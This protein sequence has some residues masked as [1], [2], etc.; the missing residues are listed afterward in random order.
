[1]NNL[2]LIPARF[3]TECGCVDLT[4]DPKRIKAAYC[5]IKIGRI[6]SVDRD[7]RDIPIVEHST[8]IHHGPEAKCNCE[9]VYNT[10][11]WENCYAKPQDIN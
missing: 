8:T 3:C 11:F 1:M 4:T 6:G 7:S 5:G 2:T 9:I 10:N